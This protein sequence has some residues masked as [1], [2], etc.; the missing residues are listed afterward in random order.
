MCVFYAFIIYIINI[1]LIV[2][3]SF[4]E[5]VTISDIERVTQ[6]LL[7]SQPAV[8]A[9]GAIQRMPTLQEIQQGL[10]DKDG[11]IQWRSRLFR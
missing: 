6:R 3:F 11:S 4:T 9:R 5:K 8:A 7:R 10:L 1:I 2:I